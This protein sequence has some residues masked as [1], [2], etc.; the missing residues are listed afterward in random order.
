MSVLSEV[1]SEPGRVL[2]K[3]QWGGRRCAG[4]GKTGGDAA[5]SEGPSAGCPKKG[6]GNLL[7]R[8]EGGARSHQDPVRER[9]GQPRT[10][11]AHSQHCPMSLWLEGFIHWTQWAAAIQEEPGFLRDAA[12][13]ALSR[14]MA[15]AGPSASQ[16]HACP[17]PQM[18][19]AFPT[20][21]HTSQHRAA[22]KIL[23]FSSDYV[24]ACTETTMA[25][26][27]SPAPYPVLR[28]WC[29]LAL[30][31]SLCL[32]PAVFCAVAGFQSVTRR[33]SAQ[34]GR[35]VM[36]AELWAVSGN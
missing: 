2:G 12:S 36:L 17:S 32:S 20:P 26:F 18:V 25:V 34:M 11:T 3:P 19:P 30:P 22:P 13:K 35:D 29:C 9:T 28:A 23:D 31:V 16:H 27:T 5:S 7:H 8:K 14:K 33:P 10:D 24:P 1:G 4:W 15:G 21:S 6:S